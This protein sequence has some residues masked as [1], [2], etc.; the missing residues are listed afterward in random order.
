MS[1]RGCP[2]RVDCDDRWECAVLADFVDRDGCPPWQTEGAQHRLRFLGQASVEE[3][4]QLAH[5]A[6]WSLTTG[7]WQGY[8]CSTGGWI[9]GPPWDDDE[10]QWREVAA[11]FVHRYEAGEQTL[12]EGM[13]LRANY[14]LCREL[15][16][17]QGWCAGS[18]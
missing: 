8:L 5:A 13:L 17:R 4:R 7:D 6:Y 18:D 11:D 9:D 1:S 12:T 16:W 2:H 3:L 15:A 14:D 10:R